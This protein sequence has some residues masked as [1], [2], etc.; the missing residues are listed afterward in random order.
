MTR[1][2]R[3]LFI[4]FLFTLVLFP[5]SSRAQM[6]DTLYETIVTLRPPTFGF[7]TVW[8]AK[9]GIRDSMVQL[10]SGIP[11]DGG[12][13]MA[14]GRRL[15]KDDFRPE[16]IV[17]VELNRRGRALK[18]TSFPAK[19]AEEPIKMIQLGN[20]FVAIS[21]IRG[22][23]GRAE[24][25]A[26]LSWY[27]GDGNYKREKILKD[28]VFDYKSLSL[29]SS[30][31]Q[32][33]FIALLH[34]ISRDDEE[35]QNGV[36]MR[37]TPQGELLWRRAYRP[38]IPNVLYNLMP[39]DEKNYLAVGTIRMDD[40][41]MAG[42][43]M[44]LGFDGAVHW[45]RTY[46][47][48]ASSIFRHAA[49]SPGYTVEGQGFVLA[50]DSEPY[51]DGPVSSWVM[52]IDALGEPR[53][54]RYFRRPDY[55]L[56][57]NWIVT[58]KDGRMVLMMNAKATEDSS[59]RNHLRM[60]TLSPRGILIQDEAYY[61]GLGARA[62][63]YVPGWNGERIFTAVIEDDMGELEDEETPIVVVGLA[64]TEKSEEEKSAPIVP[65]APVHI[66]W[67]FVAT[68]LD[69]YEDPCLGRR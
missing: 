57:G 25:W 5:H 42:W 54:Q 63:D 31:E 68:A 53:W 66:G 16:E 30:V 48:G 55:E 3:F 56:T 40:G 2:S 62:T 12:T 15:S 50:G 14:I 9:Y 23:A 20:E 38:G 1:I 17:L 33:G 46:P 44:K 32:P 13:V 27:D 41:R 43:A 6:C 65:S 64:A 10:G 28:S 69:P 18:E 47:R 59:G 21:N 49:M 36:L 8:D 51:D 19:D 4:A 58:Q 67:V 35:D 60:L 45:Q 29:S 39:I 7:P 11:Q 61:E 24:K 34:A 37:F 52:A 26:R 22:G